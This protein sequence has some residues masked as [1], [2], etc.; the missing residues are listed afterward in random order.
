VD[1]VGLDE[2]KRISNI[3]QSHEFSQMCLA[4][5]IGELARGMNRPPNNTTKIHH[6]WRSRYA[7]QWN[8]DDAEQLLFPKQYE[9]NQ[10]R[11]NM[12]N[13][14]SDDDDD[15]EE[16]HE[17]DAIALAIELTRHIQSR[18]DADVL[19]STGFTKM[20]TYLNNF[21][22]S[23]E[24]LTT[25]NKSPKL[26]SNCL[27]FPSLGSTQY[28]SEDYIN[29][30][31]CNVTNYVPKIE[32]F[33][34]NIN[35]ELVSSNSDD[36]NIGPAQH[37]LEYMCNSN[38][39]LQN[40]NEQRELLKEYA[41]S[42]DSPNSKPTFIFLHSPGG[43]GKSFVISCIEKLAFAVKKRICV[44]SLTGVAATMIPV[45][46]K[47]AST[48]HSTLH[49]PLNFKK[50]K[51]LNDQALIKFRNFIGTDTL[52][53]FVVDEIGMGAPR[54]MQ[55]LDIRLKELMGVNERFGGV[56]VLVAGDLYQLKAVKQI[57]IYDAAFAL[58]KCQQIDREGFELFIIAE[59][60]ELI[61]PMRCSDPVHQQILDNLRNGIT[62]G[63]KQ[64][65]I[66]HIITP[67]NKEGFAPPTLVV[68]PGNAERYHM[69]RL[70]LK[71]WTEAFEN[72]NHKIITWRLNARVSGSEYTFQDILDS[73]KN[74]DINNE[75]YEMEMLS[76]NPQL[77][78]HFYPGA[79]AV[80]L[81][82]IN[83]LLGL[84]NGTKVHLYSLEWDSNEKRHAAIQHINKEESN[85]VHLPPHLAPSNVLVKPI[86]SDVIKNIFQQEH[87]SLID[88]EIVIS[89]PNINE[90]IQLR[91]GDR[92]STVVAIKP[93]YDL[94]F[95]ATAHK[96]QGSSQE[97]L[98]ISLLNRPIQPSRDDYHSIYVALGR[99]KNGDGLRFFAN[100]N[101]LDFLD[102]LQPSINLIAFL[103]GYDKK[104]RIWI[105]EIAERKRKELLSLCYKT[106]S[107]KTNSRKSK[108]HNPDNL[109]F[110]S[111]TKN[112]QANK[113]SINSRS[114][115]DT[116]L[117]S[118][119]HRGTVL[120]IRN[121]LAC[122]DIVDILYYSA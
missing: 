76:L 119:A 95:C 58:D 9:K 73:Y 60:H 15:I 88:D 31:K 56:S 84:A 2:F 57:Q 4:R 49:L 64:Y 89:V 37:M 101:D 91:I 117:L 81:Y 8:K 19:G 12:S 35:V 55:V 104:T 22:T 108:Q 87:L 1:V 96:M 106:S 20:E 3:Y 82:N 97:R 120:S 93:Q 121:L 41:I 105:R 115:R 74:A 25:N 14:N 10:T 94:N 39:L 102:N 103:A 71:T 43:T 111:G 27:Q 66:D 78:C 92:T 99:V 61:Q 68:S 69:Q 113:S 21:E 30:N 24:V 7:Q 50:I 47:P 17:E 72:N 107:Q 86:L 59:R 53:L 62:V 65:V 67:Q 46:G 112:N 63:L 33:P 83:P 48:F 54:Y 44:T 45:I 51:P 100:S 77:L 90:Q 11:S 98:I 16:N 32:I 52:V 118:V 29:N 5:F 34:E 122:M 42:L 110:K 70:M 85:Y 109:N 28:L 80:L 18:D 26:I 6:L 114:K 13:K 79:P 116:V 36:T 40:N 23:Y 38:I 75:E